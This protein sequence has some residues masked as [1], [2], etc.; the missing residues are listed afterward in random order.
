MA[1]GEA[2]PKRDCPSCGSNQMV[3]DSPVSARIVVGEDTLLRMCVSCHHSWPAMDLTNAD[4]GLAIDFADRLNRLVDCGERQIRQMTLA[5][6]F[7]MRFGRASID[8]D[9]RAAPF[10]SESVYSRYD[11]G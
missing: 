11:H 4:Y 10:A 2:P 1:A 5:S 9:P 7:G 6:T 8:E 3:D